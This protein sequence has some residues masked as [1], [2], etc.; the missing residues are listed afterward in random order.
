[1]AIEEII[2]KQLGH[3]TATVYRI[4]E[5]QEQIATR[6]YVDSAEEQDILE[7]I[8]EDS[9]PK[10]HADTPPGM[11]YLLKTPFRYPPL[12]HGSRFGSQFEP[13]IFYGGLD[14]Q[15]TL[16]EVAYY[17]FIYWFS[18]KT[19]FPNSLVSQHTLFSA[20]FESSD[21][22]DLSHPK[23]K[24][25][26]QQLRSPTHYDFT[27]KV[28]SHMRS[29]GVESFVYFSARGTEHSKCAGLFSPTA[30]IDLKPTILGTFFCEVNDNY[31][32]FRKTG[33]FERSQFSVEQFKVDGVF[34]R[35]A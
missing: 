32:S 16:A 28:G 14:K 20:S 35:P 26:T 34:P 23:F 11:H 9:K 7:Q 4:V 12:R 5:N 17:R 27:Q 30:F 18:P 3:I 24:D 8:L 15:T 31:V 33:E 21:G 13:G 29:S 10:V 25:F 2:K 22:C 6:S 1:V 19:P